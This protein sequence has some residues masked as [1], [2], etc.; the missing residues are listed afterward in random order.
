M[1][2]YS[3]TQASMPSGVW[4]YLT[5]N[6]PPSSTLSGTFVSFQWIVSTPQPSD[7]FLALAP[8]YN[9]SLGELFFLPSSANV[10][11]S[12]FASQVLQDKPTTC[13][14]DITDGQFLS[15]LTSNPPQFPRGIIPPGIPDLL[16]RPFRSQWQEASCSPASSSGCSTAQPRPMRTEASR[17]LRQCH[18]TPRHHPPASARH[19]EQKKGDWLGLCFCHCRGCPIASTI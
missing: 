2:C 12:S 18:Q 16:L 13:H 4:T 6:V 7:V 15:I 3:L 8:L 17:Y 9:S 5:I 11:N 1:T 10:Y 14:N 19:C